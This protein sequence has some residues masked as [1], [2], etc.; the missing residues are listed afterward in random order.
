MVL[1]CE[2]TNWPGSLF[3]MA[4]LGC[5]SLVLVVIIIQPSNKQDENSG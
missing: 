3:T 4:V 2:E 1:I 5:R